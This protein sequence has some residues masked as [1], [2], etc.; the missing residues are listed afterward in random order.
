ML[1]TDITPPVT[2]Q[3]FKIVGLVADAKNQGIQDPPRPEVFI[4]YTVTGSFERGVL[5]K[6]ARDPLPMLD[7]LRREI[8]AVDRNVALTTTGSLKDYLKRFSY[9]KTRFSLIL[10]AVFPTIGL[11][12]VGLGV[13]SLIAYTV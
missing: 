2:D 8:W 5:V 10:L 1:A 3:V 6:T 13:Y 4:P 7:T 12:F 11:V 9:A